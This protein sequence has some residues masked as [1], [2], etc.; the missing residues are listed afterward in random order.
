MFARE[1]RPVPNIVAIYER[2][3][4]KVRRDA[5]HVLGGMFGWNKP[6][7]VARALRNDDPPT[8]ELT[9]P[10]ASISNPATAD[11][12]LSGPSQRCVKRP[13]KRSKRRTVIPLAEMGASILSVSLQERMNRQ[14]EGNEKEDHESISTPVQ[15]QVSSVDSTATAPDSTVTATVKKIKVTAPGD[16]PTTKKLRLTISTAPPA[17]TASVSTPPLQLPLSP[18]DTS[19]NAS[20]APADERYAGPVFSSTPRTAQLSMP[21]FELDLS[22]LAGLSLSTLDSDSDSDSSS[23]SSSESSS[24]SPDLSSS[25]S[26]RPPSQEK[27]K[28]KEK[29]VAQ[30]AAN[31][32]R[33]TTPS[34][35]APPARNPSTPPPRRKR[36]T[37]PP[38]W[39][40][41][42]QTEESPD[43]SRLIRLDDAPVI[44]GRR[45]RSGKEFADL[46][47]RRRS[48][49][50]IEVKEKRQTK[51]S[52]KSKQQTASQEVEKRGASEETIESNVDGEHAPGTAE[53]NQSGTSNTGTQEPAAPVLVNPV[54]SKG[55]AAPSA[56]SGGAVP[57]SKKG[58]TSGE[59]TNPSQPIRGT[60]SQVTNSVNVSPIAQP[61]SAPVPAV[62]KL[63]RSDTI[64][65]PTGARP[66]EPERKEVAPA[67]DSPSKISR[68]DKIK[69]LGDLPMRPLPISG[70]T[71]KD[72]TA[73]N[74]EKTVRLGVKST[75]QSHSRDIVAGSVSRPALGTS[76]SSTLVNGAKSAA[77]GSNPSPHATTK[78]SAVPVTGTNSGNP[79]ASEVGEKPLTMPRNPTG[80]IQP[81]RTELTWSNAAQPTTNPGG[82]NRMTSNAN[83][84]SSLKTSSS[85][86]KTT[87]PFPMAVSS[88]TEK[89]E[90]DSKP[91]P[92]IKSLALGKRKDSSSPLPSGQSS[93]SSQ[94]RIKKRKLA[95]SSSDESEG[96]RFI[97]NPFDRRAK[98]MELTR[99]GVS[100]EAFQAEM[101]KWMHAKKAEWKEKERQKEK[102]NE[103]PGGNNEVRTAIAEGKPVSEL[104]RHR[105]AGGSTSTRIGEAKL[106]RKKVYNSAWGMDVAKVSVAGSSEKR[107]LSR[108][109]PEVDKRDPNVKDAREPNASKIRRESDI[110]RDL[111][112]FRRVAL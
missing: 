93:S 81:S 4:L 6:E 88:R 31:G 69:T 30:S 1:D 43:H 41:W 100:G 78:K 53:S 52:L 112:K 66:K 91:S 12:S 83:S 29:N 46:P 75:A 16:V 79:P 61:S 14:Q 47:L 20:K 103:R 102:Q 68:S 98:K 35:A 77:S 99:K 101:K 94:P 50:P 38:G 49:A 13:T 23:E 8:E 2:P 36:R 5:T 97:V 42:V 32:S 56:N 44:L 37:H 3:R 96:P 92:F 60:L 74:S 84:S 80:K 85:A 34:V 54:P 27:A 76:N 110:S 108:P 72:I 62:L 107:T 11:A 63:T 111:A 71:R 22:N 19:S 57:P 51:L 70:S 39:V 58:R 105:L 48:T 86:L 104:V 82:L 15:S 106:A 17:G 26:T 59:F 73:T 55:V 87:R 10:I 67:K 109:E 25:T 89:S 33:N 90:P 18:P 7:E 65:T 21:N 45:T 28:G 40:G 64:I 95:L 9:T 24:D